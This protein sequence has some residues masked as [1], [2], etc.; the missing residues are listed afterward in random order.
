M[1]PS[2]TYSLR[3]ELTLNRTIV[4]EVFENKLAE[5]VKNVP[6]Q[7]EVACLLMSGNS[8]EIFEYISNDEYLSQWA[9]GVITCRTDNS[10]AETPGGVGSLRI[11]NELLPFEARDRVVHKDYPLFCYSLCQELFGY[12][13]H[14]CAWIVSPAGP[15]QTLLVV[16][17][18]AEVDTGNWFSGLENSMGYKIFVHCEIEGMKN[19]ANKFNMR[20]TV[21]EPN[22]PISAN[23][24]PLVMDNR[25]VS[26]KR[27]ILEKK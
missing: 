2:V 12:R 16:R 8:N 22:A 6:L 5:L 9:Y 4:D 18:Y 24:S 17:T 26:Q 13:K 20:D 10:R 19:L 7:F 11:V 14:M 25:R 3:D 15:D 23:R 27:A 1:E 21:Q